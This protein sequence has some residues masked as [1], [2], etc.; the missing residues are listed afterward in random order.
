MIYH[1]ENCCPQGT[2]TS[3]WEWK[4][5]KIKNQRH[6]RF[7]ENKIGFIDQKAECISGK[8]D[9]LINTNSYSDKKFRI[10]E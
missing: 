10:S 9:R 5:R 7:P 2:V 6:N 3:K 8:K 4:N 1:K